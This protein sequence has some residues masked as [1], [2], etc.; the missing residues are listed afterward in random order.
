MELTTSVSLAA[1]HLELEPGD[2]IAVRERLRER[3]LELAESIADPKSPPP[4]RRANEAERRKL[5]PLRARVELFAELDELMSDEVRETAERQV[6]CQRV[7]AAISELPAGDDRDVL[8]AKRKGLKW[9]DIR[10]HTLLP[11]PKQDPVEPRAV[12]PRTPPPAPMAKAPQNGGMIRIRSF[13]KGLPSEMRIVARPEFRL[14]RDLGL[15]DFPAYFVGESADADVLTRQV[16]NVHAR[17]L[18]TE[19][20]ILLSDGIPN[21]PSQG[22]TFFDGQRVTAPMAIIGSLADRAPHRLTLMPY[23]LQA[24]WFPDSATAHP[25][26]AV[27]FAPIPASRPVLWETIWL[28]SQ[29]GLVRETGC[30]LP[31]CSPLVRA[32][33]VLRIDEHGFWLEI[34]AGGCEA[35][36]DGELLS[37]K[38]PRLLG[39]RHQLVWNESTFLLEVVFDS[40]ALSGAAA[41]QASGDTR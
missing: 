8:M 40:S 32:P 10:S 24:T 34:R 14:G 28:L 31:R 1:R 41:G 21:K 39:P 29:A 3:L 11:P 26:G 13:A 5:E 22:G 38:R 30:L 23:Q 35:R 25:A 6:R 36:L 9:R 4:R 18:R 2:S 27:A 33:L 19:D 15:V 16:S 20:D 37:V 7:I 17:I 12:S